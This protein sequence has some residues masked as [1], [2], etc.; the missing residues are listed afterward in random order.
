M[1]RT[2]FQR[3]DGEK[4]AA[5]LRR[6]DERRAESV[7]RQEERR[8]RAKVTRAGKT[9]R[10]LPRE[11]RDRKK[12]LR[13]EQFGAVAEKIKKMP[14]CAC[15]PWLYRGDVELPE[16]GPEVV[17]DPSHTKTRGSGGKKDKQV[18]HCRRHHDRFEGWGKDRNERHEQE[19][20]V[21]T[22]R[23]AARI[24]AEMGDE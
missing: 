11:N 3:P 20:G 7:R 16:P 2:G 8:Q 1:K 23:L 12:K 17:S 24:Y 9:R 21:H 6:R 22:G 4:L 19:T 18:P 5:M 14:C 15:F 10:P 13:A